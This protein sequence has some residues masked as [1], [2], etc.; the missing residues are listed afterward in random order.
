M[1]NEIEIKALKLKNSL[2][3]DFYNEELFNNIKNYNKNVLEDDLASI[4]EQY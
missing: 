2:N 4:I 3:E 1:L